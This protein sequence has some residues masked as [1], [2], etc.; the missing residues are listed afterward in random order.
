MPPSDAGRKRFAIDKF[1]DQCQI[2][3]NP[4]HSAHDWRE[5]LEN[6]KARGFR[7]QPSQERV[8]TRSSLRRDLYSGGPS[9]PIDRPKHDECPR[10]FRNATDYPPVR[11]H[12]GT[13]VVRR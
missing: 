5:T 12:I 8:L 3:L 7:L 13:C 10:R 2:R 1:G 6:R 4:R 11:Y 9:G